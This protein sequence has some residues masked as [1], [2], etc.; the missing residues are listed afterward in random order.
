MSNSTT[1]YVIGLDETGY[2]NAYENT[3]IPD[4][5]KATLYKDLE[6]VDEVAYILGG[7]TYIRKL[8]L[9]NIGIQIN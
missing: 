1:V 8:K 9:T 7:K 3:W 6:E 2:W 4:I 5:V